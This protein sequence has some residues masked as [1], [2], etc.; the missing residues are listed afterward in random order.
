MTQTILRFKFI[1]A[2]LIGSLLLGSIFTSCSDKEDNPPP[3][4]DKTALQASVTTA[5]ALYDGSVE[6]TK[7][8]QYVVGSRTAYGTVL[9]QAKAVLADPNATLTAV[10]NAHAQLKV[11]TVTYQGNK[12]NEIAAANLIGFWKFN[13]NANDSSGSNNN[14]VLTPGH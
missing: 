5:Q 7:P 6:G 8:G 14:G 12:I 4:T 10:T 1:K 2:S 11:A 13:G 9:D 3:P